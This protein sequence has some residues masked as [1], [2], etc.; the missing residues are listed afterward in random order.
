MF[1][2]SWG[3]N[4]RNWY[5]SSETKRRLKSTNRMIFIVR[6]LQVLKCTNLM[7][8]APEAFKIFIVTVCRICTLKT[9]YLQL[10]P[11]N[12]LGNIACTVS[13]WNIFNRYHLFFSFF[14]PHELLK[15]LLCD[16]FTHKFRFTFP[17]GKQPWISRIL[18]SILIQN[19]QHDAWVLTS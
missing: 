17:E 12:V 6:Y 15:I 7:N 14:S 5:D 8:H 9:Y 10:H 1:K 2:A 13:F 3:R 4:S 18:L 11:D 16:V 19:L